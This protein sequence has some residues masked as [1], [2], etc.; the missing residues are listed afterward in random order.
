M[1]KISPII[2]FLLLSAIVLKAQVPIVNLDVGAGKIDSILPFDQPFNIKLKGLQNERYES[3]N[4]TFYPIPRFDHKDT[5]VYTIDDIIKRRESSAYQLEVVKP[6]DGTIIGAPFCLK[7]NTNYYVQ[8]D[9]HKS[10][11]LSPEEHE[12]LKFKIK[13]GMDLDELK[14]NYIDICM[15]LSKD[16]KEKQPFSAYFTELFIKVSESIKSIENKEIQFSDSIYIKTINE[17]KELN[18]TLANIVNERVSIQKRVQKIEKSFSRYKIQDKELQNHFDALTQNGIDKSLPEDPAKLSF[19]QIKIAQ[20]DSIIPNL[21]E[22]VKKL[23]SANNELINADADI[24][25]KLNDYY[26]TVLNELLIKYVTISS[27]VHPTYFSSLTKRAKLFYTLDLGYLYS[28]YLNDLYPTLTVSFSLRPI[29]KDVPIENYKG[30]DKFWVRT[31]VFLGTTLSSVEEEGRRKGFWND[32]AIIIGA[33]FK[34][35]PFVKIGA[36]AMAFYRSDKNPAISDDHFFISPF[37]NAS[38]DIDVAKTLKNAFD[39][40]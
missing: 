18:R 16:N 32:K 28:F 17:N 15:R 24:E 39:E 26:D 5:L 19:F 13:Q 31:N 34:V 2:A 40:N 27:S 21:Q 37:F 29:N 22:D 38:I 9:G 12:L 4:I 33:G 35:L 20:G 14:F 11:K 1:K 8:I 30:W 6:E 23:I 7:Y 25:K 36:G 3:L 10:R